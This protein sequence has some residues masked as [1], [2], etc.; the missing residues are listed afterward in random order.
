MKY[1]ITTI[2]AVITLFTSSASAK[3]TGDEDIV[4]NLIA[5]LDAQ[6][7]KLKAQDAKLNAQDAEIV[8][9]KAQV[10]GVP[11][12]KNLRHKLREDDDPEGIESQGYLYNT[13]LEKLEAIEAIATC[14]GYEPN[15]LTSGPSCVPL[16]DQV[17]IT[18]LSSQM[19]PLL[20]VLLEM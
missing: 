7:A 20:S 9:L 8:K 1:S 2:A 19:K 11:Q 3:K 12:G 17:L 16:V 13:L 5:R 18:S 10:Q 14:V 6:D 15:Y 4:R